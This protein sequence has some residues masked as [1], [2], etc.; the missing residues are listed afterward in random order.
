M[1]IFDRSIHF[2]A[3]LALAFACTTPAFADDVPPAAPVQAPAQQAGIDRLL[4][5]LKV[6]EHSEEA[7][8]ELRPK[9]ETVAEPQRTCIVETFSADMLFDTM[10]TH[11][12]ALF[13]APGTADQTVAFFESSAGR[14]MLTA[15]EGG[16]REG[17]DILASLDKKELA[18]VERF[19]TTPAG[20]V[21]LTVN[22]RLPE[23]TQ[24][25]VK[26]I[27]QQVTAKCG[28]PQKS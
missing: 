20:E 19:M 14:K 16:A 7:I 21:F 24:A 18:Q 1:R 3:G 10:R 22:K 26:T 8:A 13:G 5:L 15:I 9:F 2:L 17:N 28:P 11:Y 27:V 12:E 23:L 6:R 25:S 4:V